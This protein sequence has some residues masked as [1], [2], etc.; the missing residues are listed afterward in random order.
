MRSM[1]LKKFLK[2]KIAK[3]LMGGYTA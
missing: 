3:I 1:P 2:E